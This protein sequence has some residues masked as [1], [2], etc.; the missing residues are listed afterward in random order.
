MV[1]ITDKQFKS[2]LIVEIILLIIIGWAVYKY[3]TEQNYKLFGALGV[4]IGLTLILF[5]A[6]VWSSAKLL[7][8]SA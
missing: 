1:T 3:P 8:N 7:S 6:M 4:I 2:I 5:G